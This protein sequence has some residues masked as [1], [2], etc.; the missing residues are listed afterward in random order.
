[1]G[2]TKSRSKK[3]SK[4]RGKL[5]FRQAVAVDRAR[6]DIGG[7]AIRVKGKTLIR[8]RSTGFSSGVAFTPKEL[9]RAKKR[10]FKQATGKTLKSL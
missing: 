9:I 10:A 2:K 1:M 3:S 6:R 4:K 8:T 7:T 5:S